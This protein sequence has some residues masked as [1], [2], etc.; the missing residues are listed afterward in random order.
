MDVLIARPGFFYIYT[1]S[2]KV[3]SGMP[4][5]LLCEMFGILVKL[6]YEKS[7]EQV[8]SDSEFQWIVRKFHM[9]GKQNETY[10]H[11]HNQ[12]EYSIW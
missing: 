11:K 1:R 4:L 2:T 3:D 9:I 10:T 5:G 6:I 8:G 7:P 12:D